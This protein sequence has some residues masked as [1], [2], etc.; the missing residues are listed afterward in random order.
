MPVRTSMPLLYE[1]P[2]EV[3]PKISLKTEEPKGLQLDSS[4]F[5]I[6]LIIGAVLLWF[7]LR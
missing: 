5:I 3:I 1:A 4:A 6:L 7:M 2:T